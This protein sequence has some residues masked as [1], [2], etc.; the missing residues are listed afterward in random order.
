MSWLPGID[1]QRRPE[2]RAGTRP[3]PR[4]RPRRP[5][6]VRSPLATTSFGLDPLDE[7][8]D[9]PLE[10]RIVEPVPR[11]EMEVGHVEDAR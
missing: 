6:C 7:L 2:R 3:P 11:A 4:A 9:R 1:E 8:A 5:R 10:R